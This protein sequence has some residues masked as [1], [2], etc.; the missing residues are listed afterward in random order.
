M[1]RTRPVPRD[2]V[3]VGK[4]INDASEVSADNVAGFRF[5][6]PAGSAL[7]GLAI[8]VHEKGPDGAWYAARSSL[9]NGQI[10]MTLAAS[11]SVDLDPAANLCGD[12]LKFVCSGLTPSTATAYIRGK[13]QT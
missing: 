5:F 7:A 12:S 8:V 2:P 13:R 10:T 6:V 4:T 11:E 1:S 3:T 9:T